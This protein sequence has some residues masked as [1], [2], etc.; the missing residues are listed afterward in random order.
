MYTRK[1]KNAF[2]VGNFVSEVSLWERILAQK[3]ELRTTKISS[4]IIKIE[5]TFY[6]QP[7]CVFHPSRNL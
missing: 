4:T 3:N 2:F 6:K 1:M 7:Q 5:N